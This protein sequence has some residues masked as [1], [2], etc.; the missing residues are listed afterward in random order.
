MIIQ[1]KKT[2]SRP[3][4]DQL[5][6][7][8]VKTGLQTAKNRRGPVFISSVQFFEDFGFGETGLGPGLAKFGQKTELD[9]TSKH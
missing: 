4:C 8:L 1:V 6:P 2:Q 5:R 7:K 9:Q 3:V